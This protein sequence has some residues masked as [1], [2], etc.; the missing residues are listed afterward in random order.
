MR[1]KKS[2]LCKIIVLLLV[3][4]LAS[5]VSASTPEPEIPTPLSSQYISYCSAYIVE[6]AQSEIDIW[7][8]VVGMGTMDEIGALTIQ[9]YGCPPGETHWYWMGSFQNTN[10]RGMI[11]YNAYSYSS[12]VT[13]QG[14]PGYSYKAYLLVWAG[15][16]RQGETRYI[17]GY[18]L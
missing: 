18:P 10:T 16:D 6:K 12:H 8:E 17:W 1:N 15:K 14:R 11:Q 3:L 2:P 9:I 4:A 7:F 5:P 13:Y